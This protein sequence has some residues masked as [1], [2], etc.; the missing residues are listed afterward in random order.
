M[1]K[2]IWYSIIMLP[3]GILMSGPFGVA[4]TII[5]FILGILIGKFLL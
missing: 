1:I 3:M 5:G 2:N 4:G